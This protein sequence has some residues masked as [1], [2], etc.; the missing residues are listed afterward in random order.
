MANIIKARTKDL[1]DRFPPVKPHSQ[2]LTQ[3]FVSGEFEKRGW[4][5]HSIYQ[6]WETPL[7]FTCDRGHRHAITWNA[8]NQK[9]NCAYCSGRIKTHDDA[10][11]SFAEAG[12][13]LVGQYQSVIEKIAF[14]CD[15]GHQ[16]AMSWHDFNKGSRCGQCKRNGYKVATA[17]RLYYVR[18]DFAGFSLWTAGMPMGLSRLSWKR[19]SSES[20]GSISIREAHFG[21][22]TRNVLRSMY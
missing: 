3:E 15:R 5:L 18:F 21:M 10:V 8:F 6:N 11:K 4:M 13:T 20:T 14:V 17:G 9:S 7:E 16:H 2:R 19:K 22:G 1:R 12:Y